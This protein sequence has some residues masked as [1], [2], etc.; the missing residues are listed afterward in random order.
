MIRVL[1]ADDHAMV[2]AGLRE[3]LADTGDIEVV[4]EATDGYGVDVAFDAIGG[5]SDKLV[6]EAVPL[7]ARGGRI[8]VAGTPDV[9]ARNARSRT[10]AALARFLEERH[11]A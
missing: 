3:I 11:V 8:V 6:A 10:G 1:L 7:T 9:V 5:S 4:A 2:R